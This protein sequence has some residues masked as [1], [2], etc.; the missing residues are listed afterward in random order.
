MK[1]KKIYLPLFWKFSIAIIII[2]T[3]FGSINAYLIL[4][5]VQTSLEKESE[6]RVVFIAKNLAEEITKPILYEDYV[7]IQ[8]RID[9]TMK[10]DS[11]LKYIFLIDSD[12]KI[13]ISSDNESISRELLTANSSKNKKTINVLLLESITDNGNLIRDIAVPVLKGILGTLRVGLSETSINSD[14]VTS[15][16]QFW[17]M[18]FFFM[19]MGIIGAF[20]FSYFITSPIKQIQKVADNL[21]LEHFKDHKISEIKIRQKLL[22]RWKLRFRA[23]DE[24]DNLADHFDEMMSRLNDAYINLQNTQDKLLQ[25]EKLA[26]IGTI[27]SG[28]AHEI[29]NPIAGVKNC[30][31]RIEKDPQNIEQNM[32]YISMMNDAVERIEK[33]VRSLLN[34]SRKEN[35]KIE[36][37]YITD[38]IERAILL[39]AYR[40]EKSRVVITQDYQPDLPQIKASPNHI[41]QV[42]LNLLL[43]AID[44]IEEKGS[45]YRRININISTKEQFIKMNISDNG[46]GISEDKIKNIFDPFYTTKPLGHGTGLGLAVISNIINS[47]NGKI[48]IKSKVGE[49]TT[50]TIY[51]W[52]HN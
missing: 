30:L 17:M 26:T 6:K 48:E 27:S 41:E 33:V 20:A 8:E 45:N 14:V 39:L 46:M 7:G 50:F 21:D 28:I 15:L 47:H 43:N 1:I 12:G 16:K 31:R 49:G 2:V 11:S 38:I 42:I 29:N 22:N 24:I 35:L 34:F 10:L 52:R 23:K 3:I 19:V 44:S 13:L 37:V 4:K 32:K 9:K 25:S 5:D 18:V 40:L 36:P 51:L